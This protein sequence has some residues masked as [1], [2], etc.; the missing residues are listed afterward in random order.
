MRNP[1]DS[2]NR[3]TVYGV[4][5]R[6]DLVS[7]LVM[8]VAFATLFSLLR[9]LNAPVVV[10]AALLAF[11]VIVGLAQAVLFGGRAPRR[12]SIV[13]GMLLGPMIVGFR[14][15]SQ[16]FTLRIADVLL[17]SLFFCPVGYLTGAVIGG[18]F[19]ASDCLR[20]RIK[21]G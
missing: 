19:L 10:I 5:R 1:D 14:A 2:S 9:S 4:P 20:T 21:R 8:S 12:A 16:G 6:Y 3:R 18:V 17:S 13:A 7:L 11:I 15:Y